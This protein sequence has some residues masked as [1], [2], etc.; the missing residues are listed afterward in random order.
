M[1]ALSNNGLVPLVNKPHICF[2]TDATRTTNFRNTTRRYIASA[3][4]PSESWRRTL[5]TQ[6]NNSAYLRNIIMTKGDA[7]EEEWE[8]GNGYT[9]LTTLFQLTR[10]DEW[11]FRSA[12]PAYSPG[13]FTR[14]FGGHVYAQAALA[15][16]RTV[17]GGFCVH[18]CWFVATVNWYMCWCV[19][20]RLT[21][22]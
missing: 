19:D 3:L 2:L 9:D 12:F 10:L 18:V 7:E 8:N 21:V 22:G 14:A 15:A 6:Y 20:T 5:F 11:T 17:K 4:S 1:H 13:N 16:G